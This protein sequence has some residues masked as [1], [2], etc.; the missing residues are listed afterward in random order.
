MILI[1]LLI[2]LYIQESVQMQKHLGDT[3][4]RQSLISDDSNYSRIPWRP[5]PAIP[6]NTLGLLTHVNHEGDDNGDV[7]QL[8][9]ESD[10]AV[11][12]TAMSVL[13]AS[14]YVNGKTYSTVNII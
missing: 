14:S 2:K 11:R 1:F 3:K 9:D 8:T 7:P 5:L 4:N 12:T 6:S 13:Y 10:Q